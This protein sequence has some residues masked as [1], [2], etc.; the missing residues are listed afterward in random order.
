MNIDLIRNVVIQGQ[1]ATVQA[2]IKTWEIYSERTGESVTQIISELN[3]HI[4]KLRS[5]IK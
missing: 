4:T 3:T 1:I 2:Q 5:L